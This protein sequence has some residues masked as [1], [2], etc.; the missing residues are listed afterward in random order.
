MAQLIIDTGAAANDGTGDPLR[1][2]FTDT[3]LNFTAI[4][5]AGPVDSNVQITNNTIFTINTNGNL[6]LSPNGTGKVVAN[7]DVVPNMANVRNL[8]SST[9]RWSTAYIQYLDITNTVVIGGNLTV[10]GR[11]ITA[12]VALSALTAISGARAFISDGNLVAS[13]NFG[14]QVGGGGANIVPVWSNGTNWYIG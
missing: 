14:T 9:A 8:G 2:A 3:N 7:V 10:A 11:V 13:G 6:V 5:T 4:Y 1:T 12:P